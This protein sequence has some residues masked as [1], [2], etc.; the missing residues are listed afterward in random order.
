M[1]N[2]KLGLVFAAVG[3]V[4]ALGVNRPALAGGSDST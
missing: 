1:R 3:L 2:K 4:L